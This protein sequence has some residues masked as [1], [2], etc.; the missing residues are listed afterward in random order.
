GASFLTQDS[1]STTYAEQFQQIGRSLSA[2]ADLLIYGCDFGRGEAGQVALN[3]LANLT[4]ADVAASTD[5][6]GSA[7]EYANWKLE[8]TTG[9]IETTVVISASAQADW[10]HALATFTVTNAND[11]G[12][13]SLRTA[14]TN[15]NAAAG[16]DTIVFNIAGAGA[17]TI[18]LTTALPTITDTVILDATTQSGYAAGSPV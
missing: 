7:S 12:A 1:I 18:S 9:L 5:R 17:H 11:A 14:I 15:A 2:N 3:T 16:N 10:S 8:A 13:G 6:T 4:G